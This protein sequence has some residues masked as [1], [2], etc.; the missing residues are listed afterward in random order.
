M[1]SDGGSPVSLQNHVL[2]PLTD[3]ARTR[4][5]GLVRTYCM[6]LPRGF[7]EDYFHLETVR[8]SS[9]IDVSSLFQ[10]P[11]DILIIP[12]FGV[13]RM[14]GPLLTWTVGSSTTLNSEMLSML[15]ETF[16]GVSATWACSSLTGYG[17]ISSVDPK[18]SV[19][20]SGEL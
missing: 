14:S 13:P 7:D 9:A 5:L 1:S 20:L 18:S 3:E 11:T 6:D 17:K 4:F 16:S 12:R 10:L 2:P 8:F 15:L 19:T